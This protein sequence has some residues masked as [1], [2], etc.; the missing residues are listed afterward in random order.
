MS[1]NKL[2]NTQ[3]RYNSTALGLNPPVVGPQSNDE[4]VELLTK[5]LYI[6]TNGASI[7]SSGASA[8]VQSPYSGNYQTQNLYYAS[9]S[10]AGN[11]PLNLSSLSVLNS[12]PGTGSFMAQ[13]LPPAVSLSFQAGPGGKLASVAYAPSGNTFLLNG[14][15]FT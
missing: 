7:S 10:S 12:G 14:V 2:P 8:V 13:P 5:L 15:Y 11:T 6:Q 4:E 1:A 9:T 3:S